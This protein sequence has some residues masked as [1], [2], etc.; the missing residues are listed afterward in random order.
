MACRWPWVK[1]KGCCGPRNC[2]KEST[3]CGWLSAR[4]ACILDWVCACWPWPGWLHVILMAGETC[5]VCSAAGR[6]GQVKHS[7]NVPM[8]SQQID[9]LA[10]QLGR[11]TKDERR[12]VI[13]FAVLVM[14]AT[15]LP[16]LFGYTFEGENWR[17]TGF[18]FAVEDGNS[19][20]AKMARGA[21]GEWLFQT[22]YTAWPQRGAL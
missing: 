21:A 15:S 18:V 20:L 22:P 12:W 1:L 14:A 4:S 6:S 9:P 3:R 11:Q 2:L 19:Y 17:F 16:T 8:E 10:T 13:L 5:A 7:M